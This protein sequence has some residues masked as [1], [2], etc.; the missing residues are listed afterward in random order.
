[1]RLDHSQIL[2]ELATTFA[3]LRASDCR[4][5]PAEV[6]QKA[7]SLTNQIP[8]EEICRAIL[9]QSAYFRKKMEAF[10]AVSVENP[11]FIEIKTKN[12]ISSD[13]ITIDLETPTGFRAKIQGSSFCLCQVLNS[14]FREV[15]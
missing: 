9:V 4:A 7:I 5:Y 3:E 2:N 10:G 13:L 1:M 14:L 8:V 11:D 12:A 15:Q 6:W